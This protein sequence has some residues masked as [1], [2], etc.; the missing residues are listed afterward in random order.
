LAVKNGVIQRKKLA[1]PHVDALETRALLSGLTSTLT[2]S[3]SVYQPGQ[4]IQFVLTMTNNTSQAV[5]FGD[6]P[7]IDGFDITEGGTLVYR[8]NAGVNPLFIRLDTLQPGQAFTLRGTWNDVSN[9][10]DSPSV[11]AGT[12]TVTNQLDPDGPS[13]SFQ[14]VTPVSVTPPPTAP[15]FPPAS[16]SAVVSA[17][18]HTLRIGHQTS[19]TLTLTNTGSQSIAIPHSTMAASFSLQQGSTMIWRST[20]TPLR[21][22]AVQALAAGQSVTLH[23]RWLGKA[24]QSGVRAIKPGLY[25][26]IASAGDF[27]VTVTIRLIR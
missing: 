20:G 8:S 7:S 23:G 13:A 6:G 14:I 22:Q 5:Q 4:P 26:L 16:V 15:V 27:S 12:F 18:A 9:Q 19:F 11:A 10:E 21:S 3:Q 1:R 2:T 17:N 24:N 25:Q